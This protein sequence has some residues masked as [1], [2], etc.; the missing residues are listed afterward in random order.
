MKNQRKYAVNE[1]K[2]HNTQLI[3]NTFKKMPEGTKSSVANETG[4]SIATCNT[5]LNEL[6]ESGQVFEIEGESPA[7]GRPPKIFRFNANYSH[8][9][10][11]YL[12]NED[13]KKG[14]H[15]ALVNLTG[16]VVE[17]GTEMLDY[18]D[19]NTVIRL[20]ENLIAKDPLIKDISIGF[21]GYTINDKI[22]SSGIPE[23]LGYPIESSIAEHFH[24]NTYCNNDMNVIAYGLFQSMCPDSPHPFCALAFFKGKC[25][26][27]GC[28]INGKIVTGFNNYAGEVL[29]LNASSEP[30]WSDIS[31]H[32]EEAVKK[33]ALIT[34][35]YITV[36]N[37][38]TIVFTGMNAKGN[39]IDDIIAECKKEILPEHIPEMI[40]IEDIH[41]YY[42]CGL[43]QKAV[44][45][46]SV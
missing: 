11:V 39:M 36:V 37:P 21:P 41:D 43:F 30:F 2:S 31:L 14:F 15:Y 17:S 1:V 7:S 4:L 27:G 26:G 24:L 38:K 6:S 9:C 20:L 5:I 35:S 19:G 8:V 42:I 33:S 28:I 34:A 29:H 40:Y 16:D 22:V 13:F 45:T 12:T 44:S 18:I 23:L 46:S 10:C 32:Y 3:L 25:P